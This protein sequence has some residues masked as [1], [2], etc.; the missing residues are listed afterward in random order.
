MKNKIRIKFNGGNPVI[1]CNK[2]SKIL[3]YIIDFTENEIQALHGKKYLPPQYCEQC[4]LKMN[5][6]NISKSI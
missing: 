3:K 2:C 5:E 6:K 1:L 4:K